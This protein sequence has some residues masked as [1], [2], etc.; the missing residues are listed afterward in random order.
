MH[1]KPIETAPKDRRICLYYPG[2]LFTDVYTVFG[3]WQ[4][5]TYAKKPRPY[6]TND[7]ERI[8]GVS[9]T[10]TQQPTHWADV[11]TP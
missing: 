10:R 3:K 6:W 1:W 11:D 8:R 9:V 4:K 7:L 5:D 2:Q